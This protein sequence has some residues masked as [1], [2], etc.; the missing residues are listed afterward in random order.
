MASK[1]EQRIGKM[2][3]L[4][5]LINHPT[6]GASE[7]AERTSYKRDNV[8]EMLKLVKEVLALDNVHPMGSD[9]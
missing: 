1:R 3:R 5:N 6:S 8:L 2:I 7:R 9:K 4:N